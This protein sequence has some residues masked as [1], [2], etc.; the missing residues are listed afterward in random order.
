MRTIHKYLI[1][2][3]V[4]TLMIPEGAEILCVQ[5]QREHIQIW[6][7]VDTEKGK[8]PRTFVARRT[9]LGWFD[10]TGKYIG[11]VQVEGGRLEFHIFEVTA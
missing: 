4:Q 8:E 6:A 9:G 7:L 10:P 5:V 3:D 1:G 11:S 2:K